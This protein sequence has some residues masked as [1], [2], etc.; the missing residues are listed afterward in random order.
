MVKLAEEEGRLSDLDVPELLSALERLANEKD[1]PMAEALGTFEEA[2]SETLQ[3]YFA[4]KDKKEM[5]ILVHVDDQTNRID[6]FRGWEV[7]P[8]EWA[9]NE[10]AGDEA[11]TESDAA[12]KDTTAEDAT[13]KDATAEDATAKDATAEDATAEDGDAAEEDEPAAPSYNPDLH[14]LASAKETRK[15]SLKVGEVLREPIHVPNLGRI[16]SSNMF[17]VMGR[18]MRKSAQEKVIA[19]YRNRVGELLTGTIEGRSSRGYEVLLRGMVK[20]LLPFEDS[21][22][23]ERFRNG[24]IVRA[25]LVKLNE[26]TRGGIP[27]LMLSRSCR[28]MLV[29]LFRLEVPEVRER[30]IEVKA[31]A[32][33][34]GIRSKIAVKTNDGRIDPVGVCVGM[35]G[36]RVQ[37]VTEQICE[38][39]V[40]IIPWDENLRKLAANALSPARAQGVMVNRER[41][42]LEIA[43][44]D[45]QRAQALGKNGENVRLASKLVGWQ[46]DII[47]VE[48]LEERRSSDRQRHAEELGEILE[49]DIKIASGLVAGRMYSVDDLVDADVERVRAAVE[50]LTAEQAQEL[51][52]KASEV[53][54]LR[55]MSGDDDEDAKGGDGRTGEDGEVEVALRA[56]PG[57]DGVLAAALAAVGIRTVDELGEAESDLIKRRLPV[58][59]PQK[60]IDQLVLAARE[61]WYSDS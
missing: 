41:G 34:P 57:M 2:L 45:D 31:V 61:T 53:V 49:V 27:Q 28:E 7:V 11:A 5:T 47:S 18:M 22:G 56:L 39:R 25:V 42:V 21:I 13:A 48:E 38:E 6:I 40:D 17:Q 59:V 55:E 15:E 29:E 33:S 37:A 54:I 50:E 43:V 24:D 20:A 1:I 14:V 60:R 23:E 32:R 26:I 10:V 58:D 52:D 44:E 46:I 30:V 12:V 36:A 8:D 51:I 9:E 16:A 4:D 3:R 35:R 19:E